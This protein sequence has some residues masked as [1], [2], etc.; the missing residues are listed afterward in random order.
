V[1]VPTPTMSPGVALT[2]LK[3]LKKNVSF[4][5]S[6]VSPTTPIVTCL[7][8]WPG[9]NV[10]LPLPPLKSSPECAVSSAVA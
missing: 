4:A 10:R 5:S 9:A 2:G 8:V 1:I 6:S 7:V 3:R